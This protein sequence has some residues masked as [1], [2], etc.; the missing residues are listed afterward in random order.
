MGDDYDEMCRGALDAELAA[1]IVSAWNIS[2]PPS[3]LTAHDVRM[4][5]AVNMS[6]NDTKPARSKSSR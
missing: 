1:E 3:R 6:W 4:L 5:K 2:S